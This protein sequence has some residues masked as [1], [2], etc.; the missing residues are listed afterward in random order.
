MHI[1][2]YTYSYTYK[3]TR[4][5]KYIH[6]YILTLKKITELTPFKNSEKLDSMQIMIIHKGYERLMYGICYRSLSV[7]LP[8]LK[9]LKFV[10]GQYHILQTLFFFIKL[11][12]L[13]GNN[14][15]CFEKHFYDMSIIITVSI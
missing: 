1:H 2:I 9:H 12:L 7:P 3:H 15:F 6:T 14:H 13:I 4:T 10:S 11:T 5:H 8:E